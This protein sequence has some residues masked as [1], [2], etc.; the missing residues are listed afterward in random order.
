MIWSFGGAGFARGLA[1]F[2]AGFWSLFAAVFAAN[3]GFFGLSPSTS[4][5]LLE[6]GS[7]PFFLLKALSFGAGR[8]I[9]LVDLG[10]LS[11]D[12]CPCTLPWEEYLLIGGLGGG[13]I[14]GL[15][16][17]LA[18]LLPHDSGCASDT[19]VCGSQHLNANCLCSSVG[20]VKVTG[21]RGILGVLGLVRST[22]SSSSHPYSTSSFSNRDGGD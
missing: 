6:R 9:G 15:T 11:W 8:G 19:V 4:G 2:G 21:H 12:E 17:L 3:F 14:V 1:C 16:L 18:L 10:I 20:A 5:L 13:G 7:S 22:R